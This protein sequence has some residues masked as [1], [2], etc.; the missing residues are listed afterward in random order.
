M[1]KE[2]RIVLRRNIFLLLIELNQNELYMQQSLWDYEDLP[3]KFG[4]GEVTNK[5]INNTYRITGKRPY[6]GRAVQRPVR[7]SNDFMN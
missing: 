5:Q 6:S 4:N 1:L 7:C 2:T 3:V